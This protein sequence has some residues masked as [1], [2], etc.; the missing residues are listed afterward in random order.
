STLTLE[1]GLSNPYPAPNF[2][3]IDAWINTQPLTLQDLRGKVVLVDFWTYSCINCI[4]TLPYL[5]SWYK[6]YH[7]DGLVI[8][9]VHAPEFEFEKK[10]ANVQAAVKQY[11]IQYPVALDNQLDTWS[12]FNNR[13][14]PAH[15]LIDRNGNVVYTHFGEGGYAVT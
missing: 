10:L 4:R 2:S 15:Y 5:T 1:D 7:T 3:G 14:W 6:K 12:Q 11:D 13:Y 8:V 9:G